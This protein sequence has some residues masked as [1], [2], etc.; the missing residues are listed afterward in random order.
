MG[1]NGGSTVH[2]WI[3]TQVS[4]DDK[5][6]LAKQAYKNLAD[7]SGISPKYMKKVMI[8]IPLEISWEKLESWNGLRKL[9]DHPTYV[10]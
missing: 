9:V 2:K 4:Y 7:D 6:S 5:T 10:L 8:L 1:P 3:S